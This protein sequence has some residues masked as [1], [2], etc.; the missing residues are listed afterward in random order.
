[1][2]GHRGSESTDRKRS[3]ALCCFVDRSR[4]PVAV[5]LYKNQSLNSVLA[6]GIAIA[7]SIALAKDG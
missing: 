7:L 3:L 6:F 2:A 4:L 1:M 5:G